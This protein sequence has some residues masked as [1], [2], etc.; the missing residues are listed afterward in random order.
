MENNNETNKTSKIPYEEFERDHLEF[1]K[2]QEAFFEKHSRAIGGF[3]TEIFKNES[4]Y[5]HKFKIIF[6]DRI[7]NEEYD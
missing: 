4:G 3:I 7:L 6:D 5:V 1:K 2:A